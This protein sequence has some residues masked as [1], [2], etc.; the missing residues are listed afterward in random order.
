MCTVICVLVLFQ[1]SGMLLNQN[2]TGWQGV[3]GKGVSVINIAAKFGHILLA[4]VGPVVG[5]TQDGNCALLYI[6]M[7]LTMTFFV[8]LFLTMPSSRNAKSLK[9]A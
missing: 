6:T 1:Y 3:I 9:Y 4:E 2:W 7:S 8:S 5:T